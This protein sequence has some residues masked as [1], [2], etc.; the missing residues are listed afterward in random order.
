MLGVDNRPVRVNT[1]GLPGLAAMTGK[2][3]FDISEWMLRHL[4]EQGQ[5]RG[6]ELAMLVKTTVARRVLSHAAATGLA[7]ERASIHR[8]DAQRHFGASV[9][10]GLLWVRT[11]GGALQRCPVYP[12]LD[13]DEPVAELGVREGRL[14][15]DVDAHDRSADVRG[16]SDPPWRSGI[17]HDCAKVMELRRREGRLVNGHGDRVDIE[18][19]HVH[20]L[21]KSSR[22]ARRG[23]SRASAL[24]GAATAPPR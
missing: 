11:G 12:T 7:L 1:E 22:P 21:L 18:A 15:A 2:S 23:A 5:R 24:V 19:E 9:D 16:T 13:A 6:I 17:K 10:A 4:V 3:N 14:V 20:A 8:I